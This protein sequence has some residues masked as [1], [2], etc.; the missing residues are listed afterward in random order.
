MRNLTR[1]NIQKGINGTDWIM[2]KRQKTDAVINI[3]LLEIP[4]II[5]KKYE[6]LSDDGKL[7]PILSNQKI[8]SYLK[9]IGDL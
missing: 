2:T 3:P 9:E 8:N 6:G 7:L 1:N 4:K 5:L